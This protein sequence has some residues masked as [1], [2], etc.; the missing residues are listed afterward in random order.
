[1]QIRD[2][3]HDADLLIHD[4]TYDESEA[5]RGAEFFHAT[6]T[7]AGEAAAVLNARAL[8]LV[9]TSSRY[10]DAQV[11]IGEA[12]KKFSG[13]V[14]APNDLDVFEIMFRDEI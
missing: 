9:H 14:F 10:P 2:I 13:N 8:A 7:Q 6:A 4:A 11:H 5:E 1:M 3:A 12:K